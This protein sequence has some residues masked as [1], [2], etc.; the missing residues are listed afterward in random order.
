MTENC[1]DSC[2]CALQAFLAHPRGHRP[3]GA[4]PFPKQEDAEDRKGAG[5]EGVDGKQGLG[6]YLKQTALQVGLAM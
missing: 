4:T 2:A 1:S 6:A 5:G 3:N